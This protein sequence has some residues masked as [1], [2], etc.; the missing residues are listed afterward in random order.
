MSR[1]RDKQ[2]FIGKAKSLTDFCAVGI[3]L[4]ILIDAIWNRDDPASG[5]ARVLQKIP[6]AH[7]LAD[8]NNR[9]DLLAP[10]RLSGTFRAKVHSRAM[11]G[12]HVWYAELMSSG[13][14]PGQERRAQKS[15]REAIA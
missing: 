5:V 9:S 2:K 13:E 10:R 14:R 4:L 8:S 15:R 7:K 3:W 11:V 6:L 12:F 1:E